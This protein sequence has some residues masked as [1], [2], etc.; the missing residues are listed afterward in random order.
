MQ[1]HHL[2]L[3]DQA[4]VRNDIPVTFI[5]DLLDEMNP[6]T[7]NA[8]LCKQE[9]HM[10]YFTLESRIQFND[11]SESEDSFTIDYAISKKDLKREAR[12]RRQALKDEQTKEAVYNEKIESVKE[13]KEFL[14][15][16]FA[17]LQEKEELLSQVQNRK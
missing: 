12:L 17:A 7:R 8:L 6:D 13:A 2:E 14:R 4:K 16:H 9:S 15:D 3:E 1:T 11:S 10:S 5:K